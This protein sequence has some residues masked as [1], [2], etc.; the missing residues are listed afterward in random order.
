VGLLPQLPLYLILISHTAV[1]T[2]TTDGHDHEAED[3]RED[4]TDEFH[5]EDHDGDHEGHDHG[6][7][8]IVSSSASENS[9]K[10]LGPAIGYAFLV[11]LATLVGVLVLVPTMMGGCSYAR[12]FDDKASKRVRYF[13]YTLIPSFAA[14]ALLATSVFLLIPESVLLIGNATGAAEHDHRRHLKEG[15]AEGQLAWKFGASFL[16]GF[17]I[18]IFMGGIFPRPRG[19]S[20][21]GR[22]SC[23]RGA[24]LSCT[25]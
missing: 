23:V 7:E 24:R 15:N 6:D 10:P 11:N 12:S 20:T 19:R 8:A 9:S 14:G 25:P 21:T 2:F 16:G 1:P 18:P 17:L 3:G 5:D 22:L 13:V 4:H